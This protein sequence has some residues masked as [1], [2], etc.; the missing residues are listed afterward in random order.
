MATGLSEYELETL[1]ELESLG[2]GEFESEFEGESE[3]ELFSLGDVGQWA[4]GV[5][6]DVWKWATTP[7]PSR[8]A[9]LQIAKSA[10]PAGAEA[11][12][13]KIPYVGPIAG[14][15]LGA[16]TKYGVS[17]LPDQEYESEFEWET[18]ISPIRRVY[19]DVM[20]EHL[21]HEAATAESEEEAVEG[22]LPLVP[23]L[24]GKLLP[25]AAKLAPKVVGKAMPR[26]GK[27]ITRVTPHLSRGVSNITRTMFRH[28]RTRVLVRAVPTIARR[29]MQSVAKQAA[30]GRPVTPRT[31]QRTLAQQAY[32]LLTN[33]RQTAQALKRNVA[34]DRRYHGKTGTRPRPAPPVVARAGQVVG[35]R[36]VCAPCPSCGAPVKVQ[37]PAAAGAGPA[38]A[39]APAYCR[40]CGQLLR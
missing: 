8:G 39:P 18:E 32:R 3:T 26:V 12:G 33:R 24:A 21:G 16:A 1:S 27:V 37:T 13:S 38:A 40:C 10:L 35:G 22:F 17:L 11:L 6:G 25:L 20:M 2:E 19:A 28:P 36:C 7:S 29:T 34:A 9:V 23:M 31:A 30:A 14:P 15:V 5:A 4:S